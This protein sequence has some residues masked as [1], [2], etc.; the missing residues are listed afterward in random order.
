MIKGYLQSPIEGESFAAALTDPTCRASRRSSTRCSASARS[1]T[2]AGSPHGAPAAVRAGATSRRTSGSCTTSR[3]TARR[4]TNL[5]ADEPERLETLK[6]PVVLLR[7]HLQ[8]SPARRPRPRI[9]QVLAERP[10]R[11]PRP[12]PVR[13]LPGLRRRARGGR[14]RDQRALVHDRRGR[15]ARLRRRRGRALRARRRRRRAQPLRE[16]PASCATPSTG[17][18]RTSR[19]SSAGPRAHRRARTCSPPSSRPR[20]RAPTRRCPAPPAPLTLYVDDEAVGAGEIVTQP[21]YFCIVGDGI[22]VGRDSASPVTPD[23]ADR[24]VPFTGGTIDKVVVDVSG[25]HYVD[26]EA[27]VRGLVPEGLTVGAATRASRP[28]MTTGRAVGHDRGMDATPN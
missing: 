25:E 10:Q 15:G 17:S 22:C 18:A 2:R 4:S 20:G 23:Y 21:G 27:Q 9:E 1:T 6:E 3:P 11:R 7:R 28:G 14:R 13:L 16:G 8:R 5:A 12:R 26:H 24:A 19:R